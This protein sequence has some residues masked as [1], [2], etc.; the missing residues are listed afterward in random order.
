MLYQERRKSYIFA[1]FIFYM[2]EHLASYFGDT[3]LN[4]FLVERVVLFS[5]N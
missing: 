2:E 1:Y 5:I 3:V 4:Y